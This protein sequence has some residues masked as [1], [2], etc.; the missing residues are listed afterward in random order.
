MSQARLLYYCLHFIDEEIE[1]KGG[2]IIAQGDNRKE[3]NRL[4]NLTSEFLFS[5]S[6]GNCYQLT[7]LTI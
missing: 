1:A 5:K 2:L 6:P 4:G 3:W 7:W